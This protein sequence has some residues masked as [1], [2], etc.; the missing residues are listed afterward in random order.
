MREL[1]DYDPDTGIFTWR[2]RRWFTSED[3]WKFFNDRFAGKRALTAQVGEQRHHVGNL[4]GVRV[5]ASRIAWLYMTGR[6]PHE[7]TNGS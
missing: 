5:K 2:T 4:L 3:R 1:L 6:W 7:V